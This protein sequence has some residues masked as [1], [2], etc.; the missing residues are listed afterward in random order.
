MQSREVDRNG[1]GV[2]DA[3]F[4][5]EGDSLVEE[6]HDANNDGKID[7]VIVY[8]NRHRVRSEEDTDKDGK[9]DTWTT[10]ATAGEGGADAITRIEKDPKGTGKATIFE[11]YVQ[12]GGK[13]VIATREEDV[14]GDGTVDVRSTYE[15]G[16]LKN[17]EI[18]DPSVVPL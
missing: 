15:N 9:I 3:F 2:R 8:A 13:T 12:Q 7:L 14:N 18:S 10:F 4:R 17:R 1:D 11:T 16:K 5:Y 6:K